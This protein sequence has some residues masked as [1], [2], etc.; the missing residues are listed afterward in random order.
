METR[1]RRKGQPKRR[2]CVIPSASFA[3]LVKEMSVKY[4]KSNIIWSTNALEALQEYI[5][6]YL[7]NHF[8][9][10]GQLADLCKKHI[11][12]KEI[13]EFLDKFKDDLTVF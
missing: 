12:T 11:I 9:V 7:E 8:R 13:F 6:L 2:E 1:S 3:R 4:G 10:S 5:E